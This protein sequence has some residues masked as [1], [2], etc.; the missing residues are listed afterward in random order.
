M[1]QNDKISNPASLITSILHFS[2][3]HYSSDWYIITDEFV[4][5]NV[6]NLVDMLNEQVFISLKF[7]SN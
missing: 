1:R 5:V 7:S 3:C 2:F 4:S 6:N